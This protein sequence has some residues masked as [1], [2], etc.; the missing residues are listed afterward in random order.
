MLKIWYTTNTKLV[1]NVYAAEVLRHWQH[2]LTH[3]SLPVWAAV[4]KSERMAQWKAERA[5]R[6]IEFD[7]MARDALCVT[8]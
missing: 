6:E 7:Q 5:K 2:P 4:C 1:G 8:E 3:G